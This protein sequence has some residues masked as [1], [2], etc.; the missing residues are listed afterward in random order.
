V[1]KAIK[2]TATYNGVVVGTRKSP[3]PY[4]FA[5][6]VQSDEAAARA[7]AYD[8]KPTDTDHKNFVYHSNNAQCQPGDTY[9]E[10]NYKFTVDAMMIA[11]GK[12]MIAGG[13]EGYVAICRARAIENFEAHKANG[14]FE[15]GVYGWSMSRRNVEKMAAQAGSRVL[16]IVPA[17]PLI[18]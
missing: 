6:V 2:Y 4:Q 13:W 17:I 8:Y 10:R 3:R 16:A 1:T 14:G 11:E 15:P 9:P 12:R 5:V 18:K 7:Y